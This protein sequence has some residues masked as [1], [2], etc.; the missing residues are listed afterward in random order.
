MSQIVKCNIFLYADDT[1][2]VIQDEDISGIEKQLNE[3]F[4]NI[5]DLFVDN[6]LSIQSLQL[7]KVGLCFLRLKLN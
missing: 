2:F 1:C 7:Q 4:E 6:K 3:N 5:S